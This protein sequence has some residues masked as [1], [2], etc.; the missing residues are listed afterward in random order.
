MLRTVTF[1]QLLMS[2]VVV[3]HYEEFSEL[4]FFKSWAHDVKKRNAWNWIMSKLL[5][6]GSVLIFG[7]VSGKHISV[8]FPTGICDIP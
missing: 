7:G 3:K 8:V 4:V 1:Q 2:N 5:F 6:L